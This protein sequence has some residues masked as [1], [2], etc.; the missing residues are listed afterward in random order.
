M[1][2]TAFGVF[3]EVGDDAAAR[4]RHAFFKLFICRVVLEY[5]SFIVDVEGGVA[6]RGGGL[7]FLVPLDSI[8]FDNHNTFGSDNKDRVRSTGIV[9]RRYILW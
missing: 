6:S 9:P 4:S 8:G 7:S 3:E 2:N 5:V 1:E